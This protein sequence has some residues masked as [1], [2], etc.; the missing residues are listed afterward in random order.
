M[1]LSPP[2][3]ILSRHPHE[4]KKLRQHCRLLRETSLSPLKTIAPY[5]E[6]TPT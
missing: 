2:P 4:I 1:L 5:L 6:M 3:E